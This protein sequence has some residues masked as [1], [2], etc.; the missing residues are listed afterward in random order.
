MIDFKFDGNGEGI[1]RV[2]F[3]GTVADMA[4]DVSCLISIIYGVIKSH[5]DGAAKTFKSL[6]AEIIVNKDI[7]DKVFSDELARELGVL[8]EKKKKAKK[9]EE[10][11]EDIIEKLIVMLKDDE[12]E[13]GDE[14]DES[15]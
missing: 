12:D 11:I 5:D 3:A 1:K 9:E 4:A 8:S 10:S 15:E 6:I 2:T 7:R 13:G 14:E